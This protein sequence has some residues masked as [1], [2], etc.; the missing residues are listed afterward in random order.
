MP[1]RIQI[2]YNAI[3]KPTSLDEYL[4]QFGPHDVMIFD[5]HGELYPT[6]DDGLDEFG[7]TPGFQDDIRYYP[8]WLVEKISTFPTYQA[9]MMSP[10][11]NKKRDRQIIEVGQKIQQRLKSNVI[12]VN[13][14]FTKN[15]YIPG[16][17]AAGEQLVLPQLNLSIPFI[18]VNE[19]GEE[20]HVNFAFFDRLYESIYR[21]GRKL[22]PSWQ[23]LMADR[24]KCFA[25]LDHPWGK[26]PGHLH[27]TSLDQFGDQLGEI[28]TKLRSAKT[29]SLPDDFP[30]YYS[31]II[32]P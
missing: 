19:L 32:L 1:A 2:Q 27:S 31:P 23:F 11:Q 4:K 29:V 28:L 8:T 9:D 17:E 24:N 7:I 15:V 5:L 18:T 13:N 25:D 21:A 6:Y 14:V 26:H 20:N 30:S 12:L 3:V 22:W 16:L 10:T